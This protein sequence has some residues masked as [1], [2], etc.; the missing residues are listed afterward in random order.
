MRN[1]SSWKPSKFRR[2]H[3]RLMAS[4]DPADLCGGSRLMAGRI[5]SSYERHLE[6]FARGCLVDLGCGK[7]PLFEEY[8]PHVSEIVC[9][10]W[11]A[12]QHGTTYLDVECD[13]NC[14]LPFRDALFDTIVLSD[15][16]EHVAEPAKLWSEMAR[17]LAPR[18]HILMNVPF[19]YW[20]HEAPHD[21]FRYTEFALRRF[22]EQNHMNVLV[23]ESLGGAPE[24]VT[25]I[26]AKNLRHLP[27][28]GPAAAG[29]AQ[30]CAEVF[31][32]TKLGQRISEKTSRSF[33]YGYF[34]V[35]RK[36]LPA[37]RAQTR[38]ERARPRSD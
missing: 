13:L 2:R 24:V 35:A 23:L 28:V 27:L 7:A 36:E 8:R 3:G 17:I 34:L 31:R 22:A 15:V 4:A 32:R 33:P 37:V 14:A 12:T 25:D 30:A 21:Y 9:V 16:L 38:G 1:Q 26:V 5:A 10:D 29:F 6:N 20:L 18:G 19:F 11:A